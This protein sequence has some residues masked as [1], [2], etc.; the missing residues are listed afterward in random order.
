M[1]RRFALLAATTAIV[2]VPRFA[3]A[4]CSGS[5]CGA[6]STTSNY[7]AP[8]K[9]I[10]ATVTNKDPTSPIHLKFC[11]NVD[12]HCNGFD[13]TLN[14]RETV[15]KDV[16]FSG[17]KPPQI[18]AVDVVTADFPAARAA[19]GSGASSAAG[20]A[21]AMDTPKGKLMVL[22]S[23]QSVVTPNLTKA[24]E[25][26]DK[27]GNYYA[28][29]LENSRT[30]HELV[31]QLGS[32]NEVGAEVVQ[33]TS[34]DGGR[35]RDE[36]HIARE[37]ELQLKHF[38]QTLKSAQ[39]EARYA[40]SM[41]QISEDDLKAAETLERAKKLREDVEK[42]NAGLNAFLKVLNQ[43]ADIAVLVMPTDPS[44]KINAAV[45]TVGRLM[46]IIG[47]VNPM[48]QE[49]GRLEAEA[50]RIGMTNTKLK[51]ATAKDHLNSLKQQ[52]GE[53]QSMFPEYQ[54]L[55]KNTR[56]AVEASYDK[57]V[58]TQKGGN[59]FNFESLQ[60]ALI[61]AQTSVETTRKTYEMAYGVR[62]NI[63]QIGAHAGDDGTWMAFP[64][65]GRKLLGAIYEEASPA[66]DWAVKE[67]PVAEALLKRLNAMYTVARASM[68]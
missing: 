68:Q 18:H 6:L 16:S 25:Y 33:T 4:G 31:E 60:R 63:R 53:L 66:F 17:S 3:Q 32:I 8:D 20:A 38:A 5:A 30:M 50:A 48:L 49:A 67:R 59:K 57:A 43:A 56:A 40:V 37:A 29:A 10:R 27:M 7:S 61:A 42:E 46:D 34:K 15:T 52:L 44:S 19:S 1:I 62:E 28:A 12:Y 26:Y 9:R 64:G 22:A 47:E 24:L 11:V 23:K 65:E 35:V 45:G 58:K 55:L 36:A 54:E 39:T 21:V 14:P 13:V 41:F 2:A 51:V